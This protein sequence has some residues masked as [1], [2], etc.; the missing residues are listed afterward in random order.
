MPWFND[1]HGSGANP[2]FMHVSTEPFFW[3]GKIPF[4]IA[5]NNE[6]TCF[7]MR[8]RARHPGAAPAQCDSTVITFPGFIP[9]G[10]SQVAGVKP[11]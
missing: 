3:F 7:F 10:G 4:I 6:D 1:F 2:G 9:L 5:Q 8:G 11:P